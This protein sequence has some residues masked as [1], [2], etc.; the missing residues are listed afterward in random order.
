M[1]SEAE[2]LERLRKEI[3]QEKAEQENKRLKEMRE[4]QQ[5]IKE[6]EVIRIKKEK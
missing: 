6:N 3:E 4:A 1:S 2:Y 5:I